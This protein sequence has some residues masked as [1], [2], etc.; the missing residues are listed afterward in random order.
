VGSRR[1]EITVTGQAGPGVRAEFDDCTITIGP[2]STTLRAELPDQC[3]MSGLIQRIIDLRLEIT[4]VLLLPRHDAG[5]G[6]KAA[7]SAERQEE[8]PWSST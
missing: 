1:Y 3:A 4:R 5:Q 8:Q 7:A 2:E 6:S